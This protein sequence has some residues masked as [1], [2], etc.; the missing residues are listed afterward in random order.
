MDL[1]TDLAGKV[2]IVTGAGAGIGC[3]SALLFARNGCTLIAVDLDESTV[4]EVAGKARKIGAQAE[5]MRADVS[6]AAAVCSVM[7]RVLQR[8]GRV[9]V[10]FNNAGI[11]AAGKAHEVSEEMWDRTFSIN[12]K[13]IFLFCREAIPAMQRQGG[14]SILNMASATALRSVVDRAAYSASKAAVIGLTRS[15]ALDYAADGIRVNCLCPGTTDTE[16]LQQRVAA[17]ADKDEALRSFS[18]RQPLNRLGTPEEIAE[19]AL[20]LIS[21]KASFITGAAFAIDG[22][23]SL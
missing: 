13:S 19:A 22:G 16:S 4:H 10:L 11:V 18:A 2:V 14:G 7:A 1:S 6:D 8:H 15:M 17:F 12:V 9:D 21:E 20:Y 5:G 3:A 23:M